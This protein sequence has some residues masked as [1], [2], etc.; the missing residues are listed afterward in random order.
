MI[1]TQ[2]PFRMSFFGGGTDME[3]FFRENGGAVLST[4][5]DKYCYVNMEFCK[6]MAQHRKRLNENS[7][8][9]EKGEEPRSSAVKMKIRAKKQTAKEKNGGISRKINSLQQYWGGVLKKKFVKYVVQDLTSGGGYCLP[10]DT[11]QLLA[12]YADVPENLIEAIVE[13]N[14]TRKD[15]IADRVLKLAEYYGYDA[16][17]EFD[18]VQQNRITAKRPLDPDDLRRVGAFLTH[19]LTHIFREREEKAG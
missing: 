12:N 15:F 18:A 6:D 5:F 7:F 4:T 9:I 2:T 19:I 8:M 10:K 16:E 17:N 11:K 13:S 1:I 14:R 3:S